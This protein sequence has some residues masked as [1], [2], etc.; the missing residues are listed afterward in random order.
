MTRDEIVQRVADVMGID[1]DDEDEMEEAGVI[2]FDGLEDAFIGVAERFTA[3][4]HR[5]FAVYS[6]KGM[7]ESIVAED[8]PDRAEEEREPGTDPVTDAIDYIEFNVV[9][10]YAGP[11]TP[12]ILHDME[13]FR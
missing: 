9:G 11:G 1:V 7:V 8:D 5:F 3:E 12:A 13:E 6:Y 4:G 10:L 2:L